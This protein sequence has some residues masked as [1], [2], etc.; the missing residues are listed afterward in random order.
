MN[1]SSI[2]FRVFSGMAVVIVC[3]LLFSL[4]SL[5]AA[6]RRFTEREIG[7]TLEVGR[8]SLERLLTLQ[9]ELRNGKA[10]SA[11]QT[12]YLRATLAIEAIDKETLQQTA[13]QLVTV[14]E[15][16]LLLISNG[17]GDVTVSIDPEVTVGSARDVPMLEAALRGT[18]RSG[19]WCTSEDC[20]LASAAPV[21]LGGQ[22][23]GAVVVGVP[24]NTLMAADVR[25][26][27]G[28]DVLFLAANHRVVADVSS[29]DASQLTP[30]QLNALTA[31]LDAV[32]SRESTELAVALTLGDSVAIPV[33]L[34]GGALTAVLH[35]PFGAFATLYSETQ[36]W[37]L[38][39]GLT[40]SVLGLVLCGRLTERIC[41]PLSTLTEAA[42]LIADGNLDVSVPEGSRDETGVL[43][44]SFNQMACRIRQLVDEGRQREAV[45]RAN[46]V[47]VEKARLDAELASEAKS[48]FIANMSHEIRTPMNGVLGMVELLTDTDLSAEQR[49]FTGMIRSSGENLMRVLNDVLDFSSLSSGSRTE[50]ETVGFKPREMVERLAGLMGASADRKGVHLAHEVSPSVPEVVLGDAHRLE[51]VLLNLLGNAVKF[52]NEGEIVVRVFANRS[53]DAAVELRW[54]VQDTGIGMADTV[55]T[56]VFNAF[57]QADSSTTRKYGGTGLGLAICKR[58]I[59]LMGGQ[60]GVQSTLGKG[61]TFWCTV[62]CTVPLTA[63]APAGDGGSHTGTADAGDTTSNL[64]EGS[65]VLVA[66]DTK[67]NQAVILGM[68][69]RLGCDV[70]VVANGREARAAVSRHTYDLVLMDCQ[71]PEMDGYQASVAIRRDEADR[72]AVQ[73]LV[74]RIPI[75]ALTASALEGD[76]QRCLDAGMDAHITKPIMAKDLRNALA[77]WLVGRSSSAT[78][79]SERSATV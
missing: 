25:R 71:M 50:L 19:V 48:E 46:Q 24:I 28:L 69:E 34:D 72:L 13:R 73:P 57:T 38:F 64:F 29:P 1:L 21:T 6:T 53:R 59:D 62:W 66:E 79:A 52:T 4:L 35:R 31:A 15:T 2:R 26:V 78:I 10:R 14:T 74:R 39:I 16:P 77:S 9:Y 76:R 22:V 11:V 44:T 65:R 30:S 51:Q 49:R 41:R 67:T 17:T 37:L 56:D 45:L 23:F 47:E 20:Y 7:Q 55:T 32:A 27:T 5:G 8:D 43:A 60:I 33:P 12:S 61:S 54:E 68:L 42:S 75:L 18:E 40:V 70:D 3:F 36:N 63:G 58:W